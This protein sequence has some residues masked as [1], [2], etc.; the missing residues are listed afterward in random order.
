MS[1]TICQKPNPPKAL[2]ASSGESW[3]ILLWKQQH[4][5][6]VV[7]T[8]TAEWANELLWSHVYIYP[9]SVFC[10][11]A[12]EENLPL[13]TTVTFHLMQQP[14]CWENAMCL[15]TSHSACICEKWN[16]FASVIYE[17]ITPVLINPF[18]IINIE[19]Y[20]YIRWIRFLCDS[21]NMRLPLPL[22]AWACC[23]WRCHSNRFTS[24]TLKSLFS[25]NT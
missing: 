13:P 8:T 24:N 18:P 9:G 1:I 10:C 17:L 20:L 14:Q 19:I 11:R 15:F 7:T 6:H 21:E 3:L 22:P 2:P 16:S 12:R 5:N 23:T 4:D 25:P